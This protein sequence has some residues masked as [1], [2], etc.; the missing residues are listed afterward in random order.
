M[1]I[2]INDTE[3]RARAGWRLVMQFILFLLF[4]VVMQIANDMLISQDLKLYDIMAM[5]IAGIAS[6][7]VAAIVIDR[8]H[9]TD[10][11][12]A[13]DTQWKKELGL[14]ILFGFG[15]MGAIFVIQWG[16]GWISITGYGWERVSDLPYG[17]W[18]GTYF[19]SMAMVGF[20]EELIFRGY[21][22]LNLC[23]GFAFI[24]QRPVYRCLAAVGVSSIVFGMMHAGNANASVISTLN[25][26]VAGAVLAVPYI[27]TGRLAISVGLHFAWNFAQG[28]LFGFAVSGTPFRGSLIQAQNQGSDLFTGGAFGPEAGLMGLIGLALML[29]LC[30]WYL[31]YINAIKTP[32]QIFTSS[33]SDFDKRDEQSV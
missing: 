30:L 9:V 31:K 33:G 10:Y 25:I 13:W 26:I 7:W 16:F 15:V 17:L 5:G 18:L 3:H 8:R 1:N 24:D 11:G 23:E 32:H 29:G 12:L 21:Q 27:F 4:V 22:I 20:Y 14:G 28:G 19:L 6:V 2:F